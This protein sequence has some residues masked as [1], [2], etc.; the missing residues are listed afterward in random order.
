MSDRA[1]LASASQPRKEDDMD[2]A[3]CHRRALAA[4]VFAVALALTPAA[5][6][7]GSFEEPATVLHTFQGTSPGSLFGWA[8]SE[9]A[10]VNHDG[11]MDVVIGEPF[12]ATGGTTYVYSGRTGSPLYR[13]DGEADDWNGFAMADA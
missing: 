1:R 13:L 6:A 3:R 8:V 12:N 9:L 7:A 11:A 2:G 4:V 10:D 5:G